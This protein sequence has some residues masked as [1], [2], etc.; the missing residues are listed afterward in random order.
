MNK[1]KETLAKALEQLQDLAKSAATSEAANAPMEAPTQ[2][3]HQPNSNQPVWAGSKQ[4]Q[5]PGG[6]LDFQVGE[7]GLAGLLAGMIRKLSK[8]QPLTA[9]EKEIRNSILK[10]SGADKEDESGDEDE[11]DDED[12]GKSLV[13]A[14]QDN[15]EV[16]KGL[17]LSG[18]LKGWVEAQADALASTEKRLTKSLAAVSKSQE[19]V[20]S[21]IAKSLEVLAGVL[22]VQQQRIEQLEA[23]PA[24]APR[25]IQASN[26]VEKSFAQTAP[27]Q[28]LNPAQVSKVIGEMM[29]KGLATPDE[30]IKFDSTHSMTADLQRRVAEF[31]KGS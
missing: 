21:D 26:Y 22:A 3:S 18:F 8:G 9:G 7:P 4:E 27:K 5:V 30:L 10:S 1:S 11:E 12:M 28:D 23:A 19:A 31:R 14:S 15:E 6:G 13:D 29:E 17:E 2:I 24:G 20:S 25:T 16:R